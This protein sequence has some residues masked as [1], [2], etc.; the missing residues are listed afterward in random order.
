MASIS[1]PSSI[2]ID[3]L[4][5]KYTATGFSDPDTVEWDD[6][7]SVNYSVDITGNVFTITDVSNKAGTITITASQGDVSVSK[8]ITVKA[9]DITCTGF[10]FSPSSAS[11]YVGSSTSVSW[12]TIPTNATVGT[13]PSISAPDCCSVSRSGATLNI[14]GTSVGSGNVVLSNSYG[15]SSSLPVT[16][17]AASSSS[18]EVTSMTV[19]TSSIS[20]M[21]GGTATF[22]VTV[23][24]STASDLSV[25]VTVVE[26]SYYTGSISVSTSRSGAVTTVTV[27][28]ISAGDARISIF[29]NG[30][31]I[32][33]KAVSVT[34]TSKPA[35]PVSAVTITGT[36]PIEVNM[37]TYY[38][39]AVTGGASGV[40][41][42]W[43][44][45]SGADLVDVLSTTS[46]RIRLDT[47]S[48]GRFT[49]KATADDGSGVYGTLTVTIVG[50]DIKVSS[51]TPMSINYQ[52]MSTFSTPAGSSA[53]VRSLISPSNATDKTTTAKVKSGTDIISILNHQTSATSLYSTTSIM[54][55]KEGTGV[56][57]IESTDGGAYADVTVNVT[58]KINDDYPSDTGLTMIFYVGED[59]GGK[60]INGTYTNATKMHAGTMSLEL[61]FQ[62]RFQGEFIT[63]MP[64]ADA[65]YI[66]NPIG[67]VS[68]WGKPTKEG[69][70]YIYFESPNGTYRAI[71]IIRSRGEFTK[72][73]KFDA[74]LPSGAK[75][76]GSIPEDMVQ[77]KTG[78]D[79]TF[80]IP[81]ASFSVDGYSFL[82]WKTYKDGPATDSDLDL[83]GVWGEDDT[84]TVTGENVTATLYAEWFPHP[85]GIVEGNGSVGNPF[86]W[87]VEESKTVN[88]KDKSNG[89]YPITYL[90]NTA[91]N[92]VTGL[93]VSLGGE[94]Y[95]VSSK[96]LRAT[97]SSGVLNVKGTP[98]L[99][100]GYSTSRLTIQRLSESREYWVYYIVDI[101]EEGVVQYTV[102][103][104][105]NGGTV[106]RAQSIASEGESITLPIATRSG[107]TMKGWSESSTGNIIGYAGGS[108]TVTKNVTLYAIWTSDSGSGDGGSSG[109]GGSMP[110]V[111]GTVKGQCWIVVANNEKGKVLNLG[112]LE[113]VN[114]TFTAA[115][116]KIP[117]M[118]YGYRNRFIMDTG[119]VRRLNLTFSRVNPM[120]YDDSSDDPDLWS[121][122]KWWMEFSDLLDYW[123]NFG[124]DYETGIRQGGFRLHV[125]PLKGYEDLFPVI[126]KNV[127]LAGTCTPSFK[128]GVMSYTLPVTVARM[129]RQGSS[130]P[131]VK[132]TFNSGISANEPMEINYPKGSVV[133][134]PTYNPIWQ[135]ASDGRIFIGW[136]RGDTTYSQGQRISNVTEDMEFTGVWTSAKAIVVVDSSGATPT[137]YGEGVTYSDKLTITGDITKVSIVLVGGGG[138]GGGKRTIND[139]IEIEEG[140]EA[141]N[142]FDDVRRA[143]GGGGAG[144][145]STSTM[146]IRKGMAITWVI[147]KG[148]GEQSNGGTSEF[149]V[150][151]VL[152]LKA[153]GGLGGEVVGND[154]YGTSEGGKL[155]QAGG[156]SGL[157][158][159]TSGTTSS[160]NIASNAGYGTGYTTD[161]NSLISGGNGG[162]AAALNHTFRVENTIVTRTST[163]GNGSTGSTGGSG[164]YGGGGGSSAQYDSGSGGDGCLMMA[165]Y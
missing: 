89:D 101:V 29:A 162:G 126:D 134:L 144:E 142:S 120:P 156:S 10:K 109:G 35:D 94:E 143:G 131:T 72:T 4:P 26:A 33:G 5:A 155:Y 17:R 88:L 125:G 9:T 48:P 122:G 2:T 117:T 32:S 128:V 121:N 146:S 102:K 31:S 6:D 99:V 37:R 139:P 44:V 50:G 83:Y 3:S 69:T 136:K 93:K 21:E 61:P 91:F 95:D 158:D 153:R 39:A 97:I 42:T 25:S 1:G 66:A 45:T 67:P 55:E 23:S 92:D 38:Y 24:P 157:Y 132:F 74:N 86:R 78:T 163:G 30:G 127:F 76:E 141:G 80:A 151:D 70:Y 28:G 161:A 150:D 133:S 87:I 11:T 147:G 96:T 149:K 113:G 85:D 62:L 115:L 148:G 40:G 114:D 100:D 107:Y 138:G 129:R 57:R 8:T 116:T 135:L 164:K 75:L 77:E 68:I 59:C 152:M 79:Y 56:V 15:A 81:E 54:G 104:D 52:E 49:L 63:S 82:G 111:D 118:V 27:R 14:R 64:S 18:D 73:L 60:V 84:Y 47:L 123:Q 16:V 22:K 108:Y 20:V 154:V 119:V 130:V 140:F 51:I 90:F 145:V 34:V 71:I 106:S 98:V 137:I 53:T 13:T 110:D 41:V 36:N 58:A 124:F 7:G 46:E 105:G 65:P 112:T 103:F 43:E 12:Y 159:G 19:S 160:P 165:F